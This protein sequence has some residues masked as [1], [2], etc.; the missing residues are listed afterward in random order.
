MKD[1]LKDC[2]TKGFINVGEDDIGDIP[3]DI[4]EELIKNI[5]KEGAK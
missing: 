5:V 4:P 2:F 3:K 1:G